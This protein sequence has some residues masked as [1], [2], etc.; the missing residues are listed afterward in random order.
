MKPRFSAVVAIVLLVAFSLP[1]SGSVDS[2]QA[3]SACNAAQ[4]VVDVTIPDGTYIN[5]GATF[6]KTWRLKNVGTCTWNTSYALV[7]DSGEQ[8]GT[9]STVMFPKFVSPGQSVDL[10]VTLTAPTSAGLYRGYWKLKSSSGQIF[11]IGDPFTSAFWV[12]IRVLTPLQGIVSYD[13]VAEMCSGQWIY[14]G[15][16]IPCPMNSNKLQFGHVE[17]LNNPILETGQA[18]GA[19]GLLT[20]PQQKYNGLIRGMF[21]IDEIFRGDHF[22]ALVGCQYGATNCYVTY[23]L[24]YEKGGDF[25]T[26]WKF[27]ERYDGLIAPVDVDLTRL[28]DMKNIRLVLTVLASGP[29]IPDQP[30]WIAPRIV[31]TIG[32]QSPTPTTI[33]PTSTVPTNTPV[34]T[35]GAGCDRAQYISDVTIPDGTTFSPNASFSKTWRLKNVGTCTWT[36]GYSVVFASGDRM[37]GVDTLIPQTVVPGQTV[38]VGVNLTAPSLGGSYRGYWQLKNASGALFGIGS[39]YDKSFWVDIV[40]SGSGSGGTTALDFVNSVCAATWASGSGVLPC[41]GTDGDTRGFVLSVTSPRLEN[42]VTD[43]QSALLTFPQNSSTGYIQGAYPAFGVQAGD[44]FKAKLTCEYGASDCF[45]IYRLDYRI[46]GGPVQ[47]L[48]TFGERYDGL[49]YAA[50][51]DLSALAGQNVNFILTILANGSAV[52][53]RALWV[54]PRVVRPAS[55]GGSAPLLLEP[56]AAS[57]TKTATLAPTDTAT[58]TGTANPTPTVPDA[59][60]TQPSP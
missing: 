24:E 37:G 42:G 59:T 1:I 56:T 18:A 48:G 11:G 60:E 45:V 44:R 5:P 14:D 4:F 3:A 54:A 33:P 58:P 10:T 41:P 52:G 16:P 20:I 35:A 25:F 34:P 7:F 51:I 53:D 32:S 40:V 13:F 28:A 17:K 47:T 29:A 36:T 6:V 8:M 31:R 39:T 46:G 57:A 38:D 55:I 50:D 43:T 19:Q 9:T 26:L 12:E 2:A 22:Q 21:Q 23:M 27:R 30:L 49:Y 15:G